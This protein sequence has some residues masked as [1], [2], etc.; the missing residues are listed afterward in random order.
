MGHS[1][2]DLRTREAGTLRYGVLGPAWVFWTQ[3]A[4][5]EYSAVSG[6]GDIRAQVILLDQDGEQPV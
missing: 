5:E 6:R 1:D 2:A 4:P 3:A